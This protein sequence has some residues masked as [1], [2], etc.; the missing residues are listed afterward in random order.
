MDTLKLANIQSRNILDSLK[1]ASELASKL[2]EDLTRAHEDIQQIELILTR[3][4]STLMIIAALISACVI[5]LFATVISNYII[6]TVTKKRIKY[7]GQIFKRKNLFY[8][9]TSTGLLDIV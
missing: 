3:R 8:K 4:D 9:K 5:A 2:S 1:L 7:D 6:V